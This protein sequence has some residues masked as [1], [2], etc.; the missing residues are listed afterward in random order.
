MVSSAGA[1][2]AS[3]AVLTSAIGTGVDSAAGVALMSTGTKVTLTVVSPGAKVV[4]AAASA[5]EESTTASGA[6]PASVLP[7]DAS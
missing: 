1:D 6:V 2:A 5:A 3:G 7:S 4:P